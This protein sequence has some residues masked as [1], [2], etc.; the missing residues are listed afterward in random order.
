MVKN[1]SF[2]SLTDVAVFTDAAGEERDGGE[3]AQGLF[4]DTL[5]VAQLLQILCVYWPVGHT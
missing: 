4:D 2:M 5:Q 1:V 3:Q